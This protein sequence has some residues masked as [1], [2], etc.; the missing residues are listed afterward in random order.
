MT[1]LRAE[2]S[3]IITGSLG[4][5][6]GEKVLIMGPEKWMRAVAVECQEVGASPLLYRSPRRSG[7]ARVSSRFRSV[8]AD[9]LP[10][11]V[12][13]INAWVEIR[14]PITRRRTKQT[15]GKPQAV[16]F[17][18]MSDWELRIIERRVRQCEFTVPAGPRRRREAVL[19]ALRADVDHMVAL[20]RKLQEALT[21]A[22]NVHVTTELGTDL[23]L[24]LAG[25]SVAVDCGRWD[26]GLQVDNILYVPGGV[27]EVIPA[28]AEGL[29]I[30]PRAYLAYAHA[31]YIRDLRL[32]FEKGRVNLEIVQARSGLRIFNRI[33]KEAAGDK[34]V[35]AEFG[36]GVNPNV[37]ELI[38]Y[39]A[40]DEMMGGCVHI[41][42]GD[43][44]WWMN[45]KNK[46]SLHWDFVLP[47][48]KVELDGRTIMN[49]GEFR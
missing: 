4:I 7:R 42:I 40:V 45:G 13:E 11:V 49:R 44:F 26:P 38:R 43:N 20:G 8:A 32:Q 29:V 10:A 33:L 39:M 22:T 5:K 41:A 24:T 34:D 15:L 25:T 2:L 6:A 19:E 27:V 46:S 18:K 37:R 36:I 47:E 23:Y 35:I 3:R 17:P 9:Q 12:E 31:G 30:V 1:L 14:L 28:S 48:A 16:E 21:R